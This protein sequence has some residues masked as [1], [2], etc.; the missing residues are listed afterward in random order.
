MVTINNIRKYFSDFADNHYQLKDFGYGDLPDISMEMAQTYPLLWIQPLPWSVNDRRITFKYSVFVADRAFKERGLQLTEVHSD[1]AQILFDLMASMDQQQD[2]DWELQKQSTGTPFTDSWKDEVS[3]HFMDIS[4]AVDFNY[5]ECQIPQSGQP[6]PPPSDLCAD[7]AAVLKD[8]AG[9]TISTTEV[10]SGTTVNITAPDATAV[11]K[12]SAG[13]T[14]DSETILSG[15]TENIVLGDVTIQLKNSSEVLQDTFVLAA[16]VNGSH[17]VNDVGWVDSDGTLRT[18]PYGDAIS[19]TPGQSPSGIL[20]KWPL[21]QQYTSYRPGDVGSR[22]QAGYFTYNPPSYP[23]VIAALDTTQ[24]ANY[25]WVLKNA[26]KVGTVSS[27]TRFTD[28]DGGQDWPALNNK[29][30]MAVDKYS[31]IGIYRTPDDFGGFKT[32]AA[33]VDYALTFSVTINGILYDN[34]YL[35]SQEELDLV[36]GHTWA[37]NG[38][39]D[40]QDPVTLK[41]VILFSGN[42]ETWT[43]TTQANNSANAYPKGWN[44][45]PFQRGGIIKTNGA[46]AGAFLVCDAKS[47]ITA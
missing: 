15:A 35:V 33:A 24:G 27:T 43:S 34:W 30:K 47:L 14:L 45:S 2:Y 41:N 28:V 23:E 4:I 19:C 13:T 26:L 37:L 36:T 3:G 39:N 1:T 29:D 9:T 18:T 46:F 44:A 38:T 31:G 12:N 21:G 42:Y 17:N 40:L 22:V 32:W 8:S 11:V 25:W 5:N 6:D 16:G 20:L 7:G 10:P